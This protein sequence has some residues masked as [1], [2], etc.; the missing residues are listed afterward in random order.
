MKACKHFGAAYNGSVNLNRKESTTLNK[1][2]HNLGICYF[3]LMNYKN[4]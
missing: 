4:A 1:I 2:L 3:K